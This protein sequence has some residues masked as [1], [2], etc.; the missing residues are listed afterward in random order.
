MLLICHSKFSLELA[1]GSGFVSPDPLSWESGVWAWNCSHTELM[2]YVQ[3]EDMTW[4]HWQAM[5]FISYSG[6]WLNRLLHVGTKTFFLSSVT[7]GLSNCNKILVGK[8]GN[9]V[10]AMKGLGILWGEKTA[11]Y[12]WKAHTSY[13]WKALG[14]YEERRLPATTSHHTLKLLHAYEISLPL[15]NW[16]N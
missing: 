5:L 11:S 12:H 6:S 13:Q 15:C 9:E 16:E 7:F 8:E 10:R 3:Y 4:N 14:F 2:T 1:Q